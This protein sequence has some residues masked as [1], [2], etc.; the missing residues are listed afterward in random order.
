MFWEVPPSVF[1]TEG[2]HLEQIISD[3]G[4]PCHHNIMGIHEN[5]ARRIIINV[6]THE[7][8]ICDSK[9]IRSLMESDLLS[10]Q[11]QCSD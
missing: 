10:E 4:D 8:K 5:E 1:S 11:D 9:G 3:T 2:C 7:F 6:P